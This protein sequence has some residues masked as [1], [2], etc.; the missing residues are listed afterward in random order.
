[1][2]SLSLLRRMDEFY[3]AIKNI[4]GRKAKWTPEQERKR[5]EFAVRMAILVRH[6]R[7]IGRKSVKMRRDTCDLL[8]IRTKNFPAYY[9]YYVEEMAPMEEAFLEDQER[10]RIM[11]KT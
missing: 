6:E 2:I 8:G 5:M 7:K 3:Y 9:A 1:M 4:L 10:R 11:W